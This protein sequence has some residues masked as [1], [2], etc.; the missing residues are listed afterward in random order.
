MIWGGEMKLWFEIG[1]FKKKRIELGFK[2]LNTWIFMQ[3]Q[4]SK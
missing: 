1:S 3:L 4:I 2:F